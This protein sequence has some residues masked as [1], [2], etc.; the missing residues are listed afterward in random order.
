MANELEKTEKKVASTDVVE[1]HLSIDQWLKVR[2]EAGLRIDPE[3]A[4]VD[5]QYVQVLDPYGIHPNLPKE[6]QQVGRAYFARSPESDIWVWFGDL[7]EDVREALWQMLPAKLA[8][9]ADLFD[10]F[11]DQ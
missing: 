5:W 2:K 10:W 7:P 9:T 11:P 4:E 8:F 6:C 3:T 1:D